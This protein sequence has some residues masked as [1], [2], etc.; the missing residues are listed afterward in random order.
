MWQLDNIF[1]D[2]VICV[3]TTGDVIFEFADDT[4]FMNC[5]E[6]DLFETYWDRKWKKEGKV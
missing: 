5:T 3:N 4:D 1:E 6:N 2:Q